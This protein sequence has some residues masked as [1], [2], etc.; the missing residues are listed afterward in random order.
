MGCPL[1]AYCNTTDDEKHTADDEKHW[2]QGCHNIFNMLCLA[3]VQLR[4]LAELGT[5]V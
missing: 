1:A 2:R 5:Y 3:L 4:R